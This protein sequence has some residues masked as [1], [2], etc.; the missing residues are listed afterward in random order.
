MKLADKNQ[1]KKDALIYG[2]KIP[3]NLDIIKELSKQRRDSIISGLDTEQIE[4]SKLL[5]QLLKIN[6][7]IFEDLI[8]FIIKRIKFLITKVSI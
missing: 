1:G 6:N 5:S 3:E 8:R 7:P 2:I 4:L